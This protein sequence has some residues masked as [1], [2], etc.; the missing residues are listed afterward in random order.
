MHTVAGERSGR[1]FRVWAARGWGTGTGTCVAAHTR[2]R[3][4]LGGRPGAWPEAW[5]CTLDCWQFVRV[6]VGARVFAG[7]IRAGVG[8][9]GCGGH[10][11]ANSSRHRVADRATGWPSP[12]PGCGGLAVRLTRAKRHA[13]PGCGH[14]P[15]PRGP[16]DPVSTDRQNGAERGNPAA[17]AAQDA[18]V[19]HR[20]GCSGCN[21]RKC[22]RLHLQPRTSNEGRRAEAERARAREPKFDTGHTTPHTTHLS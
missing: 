11:G 20:V 10:S 7:N 3:A 8:S 6:S 5:V 19:P 21:G 9:P 16:A 14:G 1:D 13:T 12:Q 2:G 4:R 17:T 15:R 22:S 18:H